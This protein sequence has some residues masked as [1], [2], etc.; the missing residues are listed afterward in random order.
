MTA[1]TLDL[2]GLDRLLGALRARGYTVVGP[3][4]RSRAIVYDEVQT[5]ADLPAGWVDET[6][7]GRYRLT[8]SDDAALFRHA[9]G[10]QSLKS[11]LFPPRVRAWRSQR[12]ADGGIELDGPE[13]A[14]RYAFL[15][16]RACDLRPV[17]IQDRVF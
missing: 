17:A 15:G 16:V 12:A 7:G 9:V 13:P 8:R 1:M 14:P 4:E 10:P 3:R 6:D 5:I 11:F 2:A